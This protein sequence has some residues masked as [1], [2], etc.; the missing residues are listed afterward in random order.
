MGLI[1]IS[2]RIGK[3]HE[4]NIIQ[5]RSIAT[6]A[7]ESINIGTRYF[8]TKYFKKKELYKN[9]PF[10]VTS[11][12]IS[13]KIE[14]YTF[15]IIPLTEKTF[16][17]VLEPGLKEKVVSQVLSYVAPSIKK[18]QLI[19]YDKINEYK[20]E[21]YKITFMYEDFTKYKEDISLNID[22]LKCNIIH[23]DYAININENHPENTMWRQDDGYTA[24][25]S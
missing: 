4:I 23:S 1:S 16:R 8:T 5:S 11:E 19:Y 10:V 24:L 13:P 22:K 17:L 9:A 6:K 20:D 21:N 14:D 25:C 18:E 3:S 15:Q 2:Q 7:L 12:F